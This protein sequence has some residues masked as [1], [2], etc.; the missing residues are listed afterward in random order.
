MTKGLI[1]SEGHTGVVPTTTSIVD[2]PDPHTGRL[3]RGHGP[4]E[5]PTPRLSP[6]THQTRRLAVN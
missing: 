2:R 5:S 6:D 3:P 4:V 1:M